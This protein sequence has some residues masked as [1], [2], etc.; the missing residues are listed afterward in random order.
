VFVEKIFVL[1]NKLHW[2]MVINIGIFC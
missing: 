1:I 2:V